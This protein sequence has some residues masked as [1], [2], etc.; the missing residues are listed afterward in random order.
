MNYVLDEAVCV[1]CRGAG[2]AHSY[3]SDAAKLSFLCFI[4]NKNYPFKNLNLPLPPISW[5]KTAVVLFEITD[6]LT[7]DNYLESSAIL[8]IRFK[9]NVEAEVSR[10]IRLFNSSYSW[11]LK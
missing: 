2:Q 8:H 3:T 4:W 11:P 10:W 5:G 7:L 6:I 9:N 1:D